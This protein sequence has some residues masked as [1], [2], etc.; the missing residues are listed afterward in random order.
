MTRVLA[1]ALVALVASAPAS[2]GE[3]VSGLRAKRLVARIAAL[4]PRPAGS[5]NERR[6][7]RIVAARFRELGLPVVFQPF[8]L[9]RGGR[10]RNVVARTPGRT[11]VVLVAHVDG[12]SEGPAANDNGSGVAAVVE[13]AA[14]LHETPGV[15]FAALGAE[16]R[17]ETGSRLHLG[18]IRL[19]QSLP[20]AIRPRIRLA[21][22][23][24]MAGVGGTL[25]IRGLEA[26]PNR[27]ARVALAR[28]R[29]LRLRPFYL[30]DPG[31]SDHAELTRGGIPAALVTWRW[32]PC[33]HAPC[34]RAVRVSA[35][36]LAGAA[37][38]AVR[39]SRFV[40]RR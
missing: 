25:A 8:P 10:S 21:L 20:R 23:L 19:L 3:T 5:A 14:V 35:R 24:D 6:A 31:V 4:G 7:A 37:R 15:L 27:S 36:K 9:P 11:R 13:A 34:D 26:Q 28:A 17:V 12:V 22:S 1:C 32:D 39:A 38:L 16:E 30:R 29:A 2:A 18:A 40:L 33:W